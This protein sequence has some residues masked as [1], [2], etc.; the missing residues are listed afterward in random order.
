MQWPRWLLELC[1]LILMDHYQQL[2]QMSFHFQSQF[3]VLALVFKA[4]SVGPGL[5]A[6]PPPPL[7]LH[8]CS[9]KWSE[10]ALLQAKGRGMAAQ[11]R[12]FSVL[13]PELWSSLLGELKTTLSWLISKD[14][15]WFC[16]AWHLG[17]GLLSALSASVIL[18]W[19]SCLF[20]GHNNCP[21]Q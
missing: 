2:H 6:G 3:K 5:S 18:F 8:H 9:L 16:F 15:K 10:G 19:L 17:D 13:A 7:P 21:H 4:H 14:L 20:S 12:A 1:S 11:R